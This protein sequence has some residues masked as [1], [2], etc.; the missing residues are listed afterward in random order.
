MSPLLLLML[1]LISQIIF[2]RKAI[3]QDIKLTFSTISLLNILLQIVF[4]F[5]ALTNF[6]NN[7]GAQSDGQLR[8]GAAGAGLM[9]LEFLIFILL[10]VVILIQFFIKRSYDQEEE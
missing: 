3:G 2:G 4:S 7:L 1:P 5:L 10:L 6:T 9:A 8:C